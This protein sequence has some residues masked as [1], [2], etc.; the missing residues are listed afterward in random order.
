[1]FL[2][3]AIHPNQEIHPIMTVAQDRLQNLSPVALQQLLDEDRVVLVDVREP[4]EFASERIAGARR[5]SLSDFDLDK[6]PRDRD[7]QLVL[8]CRTG[9]RSAMAAQRLFSAGFDRVAHLA[10]GL[11]NWKRA[12]YP[13][14][15]NKK[16]PISLMRQVQIVAGSM[17]LAGTLL[18]AFVSP[19]FLFLSGFVGAGLTFAGFSGTCALGN[20]LSK[21]P[22]N[23]QQV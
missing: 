22:Y 14:L 3:N 17:V 16:A 10:G 8:Y 20:L 6:I 11:E 21:L 7:R 23:Q 12:G 2:F 15:K 13:T 19:G 5:M 4:S 9:S 1:L 18:G